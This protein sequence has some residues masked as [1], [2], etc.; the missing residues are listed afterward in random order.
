MIYT[1]K[2]I[3]SIAIKG[4]R[5]KPNYEGL[6]NVAVSDKLY[7]IKFSNRNAT[8]LRNG[9]VLSQ[10]DGEGMRA[11]QLQ[12][13]QAMKESLKDH[14]LKQTSQ[15][16]GVNI[17]D[18]RIPSEA[19]KRNIRINNM[20]RT[21]GTGDNDVNGRPTADSGFGNNDVNGIP[22]ADSGFGEGNVNG[23]PTADSGFG[24][25]NVNTTQY[26]NI[27]DGVDTSA[28]TADYA[29][30]VA[31]LEHATQE[32]KRQ[33]ERR[34][35]QMAEGI[36]QEAFAA[37]TQQE[38]SRLQQQEQDRAL[39]EAAVNQIHREA[40][41]V[42]NETRGAQ[43]RERQERKRME[44]AENRSR[45]A[46]QKTE[47]KVK[48]EEN[49]RRNAHTQDSANPQKNKTDSSPK[50][51]GSLPPA[52]TK[53]PASGSQDTPESTHED[54]GKPGRPPNTQPKPKARGPPTVQKDIF[55]EK[56]KTKAKAKAKA[57]PK[58]DTE[59]DNNTD[60]KYWEAK[61][62]TVIK[63]QLNKRG[64]RKHRTPD[65]GRMKKQTI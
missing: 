9:F 62:L 21:T 2:T 31:R 48:K 19:K 30:R 14:L 22:T 64:Y 27:S 23:R 49:R 20:L 13:E 6:I 37:L 45:Q 63:D 29:A 53:A 54:R 47:R 41:G 52:P 44:D 43:N 56:A 58:H 7:N 28:A 26:F 10:L 60:F 25:G 1:Y 15:E 57:N 11:M 51:L 8:F 32:E 24:E 36:R 61:N 38:Q 16:T 65:G 18:L 12:E 17:S 4:L 3:M 33:M 42:V 35:E 55:K 40:Q 39:A 50:E 46:E 34:Y 59:V 5:V